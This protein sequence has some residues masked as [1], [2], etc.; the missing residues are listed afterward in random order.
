MDV[1]G[2]EVDE[3]TGCAHYRSS[4]DVIAIRMACCGEYYA[5]KDCHEAVADHAIAVWPRDVWHTRAMLCGVCR[6][7]LT[8]HEYMACGNV[9]P[10]CKA[11]FNPG[12]RNH[13]HCYFEV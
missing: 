4:R 1:K 13:Y 5:C 3:R 10:H 8:I 7:E 11:E 2:V 12:C 6:T 9:C